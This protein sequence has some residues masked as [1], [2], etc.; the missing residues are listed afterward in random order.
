M[1]KTRVTT[2]TSCKGG[3]GKSTVCANLGAALAASG[4][5]VL[6]IDLDFGMRCLDLICGFEDSAL[7]DITDIVLRGV[8]AEKAVLQS[9]N[10]PNL[11]FCAA[12]YSADE[13]L[14]KEDFA[15]AIDRIKDELAPD[16]ILIDTHG[17]ISR[18]TGLAAAVSDAAYIVASHQATAVR[19]AEKTDEYLAGAGV[20]ETRLIIN[21][22]N[23]RAVRRGELPG[24]IDVIDRSRVRL[25]GIV[26]EY[27]KAQVMQEKGIL[28]DGIGDCPFKRAFENIAARTE[29][30][31]VPLFEGFGIFSRKIL[32]K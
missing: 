1:S 11:F 7:Y 10:D 23:K 27:E 9:G 13:T 21:R 19:A 2:V 18:E 22:F 8:P 28:V 12:P 5:K 6:L 4:R 29:G 14:E 31:N 30:R 26:P 24:V 25:L 3:V 17:G 20:P 32:L 15:S 16:H